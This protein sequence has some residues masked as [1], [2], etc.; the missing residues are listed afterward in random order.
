MTGDLEL[1]VLQRPSEGLGYIA[2]F[3]ITDQLIVAA[4]GTSSRSPTVL[5]SSNARHFEPRKTPRALGMRDVIAVGDALWTC[6]EYG[7]L[8]I[9]RDNGATWK[10]FDTGTDACLFALALGP[11]GAVWVVGD[12]GYTARVPPCQGSEHSGPGAGVLGEKPERIDLKT[13]ARLA[14]VYALR[15]E[16]IVLGFDGVMYRWREGDVARI[17]TG[18]ARPLTALVVTKLG[19]WIVIGDGGFIARSP[20]G[21]WWSRV[22]SSADG[23]ADL[24]AIASCA[25]GRL[26]IV[27]DQGVVLVSSDDGRQWKTVATRLEAH[28]WAVERFGDGVLIG[29]DN[30]L[31]VKLAPSGDETWHD[32]INIFGGAK[33]LDVAFAEGPDG[34]I[35]RGLPHYF[36]A[37]GEGPKRD[38]AN[39]AWDVFKAPDTDVFAA[40]Y[41]EPMPRDA[42]DFFAA[43]DGRD[44]WSS[45][46][47]LRLD[48]Q[49]PGDPGGNLFELIVQSD[50]HSYLGTRLVEA[51]CGVFGLGSQGNGDTYHLELNGW[52]GPRQ[53]LHYDH[54]TQAFTGVFADSLDS[55]VY[56]AALKRAHAQ[57]VISQE[58]FDIGLRKLRGRVAPTWHFA[59]EED[60][61]EFVP[62]EAKRRDTEFFFYRA[63]W[64]FA[65]LKSDGVTDVEDIPRLFNADSNQVVPPDQLPA[66]Y[67][68]CEKAIPTA[69]YSMWRA[70]LFDEPELA[71]YLEIGR[72]HKSLLVRSAATL[73]DEL[74]AGRN[75]LG[76]IKDMRAHVARFRALDLDPRRA[77]ARKA[78]GEA[79]AKA[80]ASRHGDVVAELDRAPRGA[81]SDL[82]W[83][84]LADGVAHRALLQR[85]NTAPELASQIAALDELRGIPDIDRDVMLPRLASELAP[86]LEAV[87][88]GSLVRDDA[89]AGV[90]AA[91]AVDEDDDEDSPG[92]DAIDAALEPIYRGAEPHAHFGAVLPYQLGGNDPI[93]GI[94]A[95]LRDAPVP[96]F[97]IV[98][99]GFTD[100]FGKETDDPEVSGFG[101]ELTMRLRRAAGDTEV[102]VWVLN[103]LQN[104]GRYVFGTG[105]RFGV[106]HKMGLNGPIALDHDTKL[107]AILFADDPEL[108]EL[109]SRFG[110]ARFIQIVGITDDE[111]K[112]IQEW[113]TSGL[114]EILREQ[115]PV[116]VTDLARDSVLADAAVAAKVKQRVEH[117]GSSEDLTFAGE[118]K[119]DT[120][121]GRVRI[122]MG[123]LYAA[124]LPRA[125]R[126]RL[127]H[128][129]GYTLR[130]RNSVLVLE[131]T[132]GAAAASQ[133]DNHVVLQLPSQ[134]AG[135]I[136]AR[137]RHALA[138]H[139]RFE[140]WP[141]LEIIVTPS[142]IRDQQG[143][144][145][146]VRGVVGRALAQKLIDDENAR[147]DA[148][149]AAE[150]EEV[151]EGADAD[152]PEEDAESDDDDDDAPPPD[153]VRAAL[154]MTERALRL[155]PDDDDAQFT[156]AMLL[157]DAD[158]ARLPGKLDELLALLPRF[159][160]ANRIN[161]AVRMGKQQHARFAD[162]L[163]VV[164]AGALPDRILAEGG[165]ANVASYGDVAEELFRELGKHVIAQAPERLPALIPLLPAKVN[166]IAQLAYLAIQAERRVD[167]LALYDRMLALS[168]PDDGDERTNY[169][170]GLNNACVQAHAAKAYDVAVKIADRAQPFAH[171]NP[172]IYH[173]A[174][175]AYAAVG[176]HAK[177]FEQVKLAVESNYDHLGKVEVDSD[178]GSLL[179]WP[180]FKQLF[181]DW[182]ARREDK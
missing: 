38:P 26:V 29:G 98:T 162:A 122:E 16:V 58:A 179:E 70:Y 180:E 41:G 15:D 163:D 176:D 2:G 138:G 104:L 152:E 145:I 13:T 7:Q 55:L 11:D 90:L 166:L 113:S 97:H 14:A 146:D 43:I 79:K 160:V 130:G 57:R 5:A 67:E 173:S 131:P 44:K 139:Y 35:A 71:P 82:A 72:C 4:G 99:Y 85:L 114:V 52:D 165:T 77:D 168:I 61:P 107:T 19:T 172:Y 134:L 116:L 171:E 94:S 154:A 181:R 158:R 73:I 125:M 108:G 3:A 109:S 178:L 119:L 30:G 89:L 169:L 182:H 32:R 69:L 60:D 101:F 10:L 33:P 27:G 56:L 115:L 39:A 36:S 135:E 84:W 103:F 161:I 88:V 28:L 151:A 112:L 22:K 110:K 20:D 49:L 157:L 24:E 12:H 105:N 83:R 66:R 81:W 75:E 128:G 25:D 18:A 102:P 164:L 137:L 124:A 117:E 155:V 76:T 170:R 9:S 93:H 144:A 50:H 40:V 153:R 17:T 87:L 31:I 143:R 54:E 148:E 150:A 42:A 120:S 121:D 175:C 127:R 118:L 21:A 96:H 141:A 91:P 111:Y 106:G 47:E 23:A 174:A 78:E 92:W 129:R 37:L 123:A 8:A 100:L 65:L 34:F 95:Y 86:E 136:E 64:I 177:A 48:A 126:G 63:R 156:H 62:L 46:D 132:T 147:L 133:D 1:S 149:A 142:L 51:F 59:I 80:D 45:F 167:S 6:G 74:V 159:D 140:M 53:V 68:A